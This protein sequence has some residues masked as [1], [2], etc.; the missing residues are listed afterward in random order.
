MT[1]QL[2]GACVMLEMKTFRYC[3]ISPIT[4]HVAVVSSSGGAAKETVYV[5][6]L[7]GNFQDTTDTF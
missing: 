1:W 3:V 4:R 6:K 2:E 5:R 7:P